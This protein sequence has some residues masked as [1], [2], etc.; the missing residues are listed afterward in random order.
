MSSPNLTFSE[1]I[2]VIICEF[3]RKSQKQEKVWS[4]NEN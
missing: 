3:S 1:L 4:D 2:Q